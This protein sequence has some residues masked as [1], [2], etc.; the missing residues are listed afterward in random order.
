MNY[1]DERWK[2]QLNLTRILCTLC[3]LSY[4]FKQPQV[5]ALNRSKKHWGCIMAH[6]LLNVLSQ[7][8]EGSEAAIHGRNLG[9]N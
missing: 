3:T 5:L 6:I 2:E 4:Q 1:G 7:D 9:V 8:P